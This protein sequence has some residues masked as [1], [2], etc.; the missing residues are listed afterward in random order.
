MTSSTTPSLLRC[1]ISSVKSRIRSQIVV[2]V[3]GVDFVVHSRAFHGA[4]S[5]IWEIVWFAS[6]SDRVIIFC[7]MRDSDCAA[8][9]VQRSGERAGNPAG[10]RWDDR[11]FTRDVITNAPGSRA[12]AARSGRWDP[13]PRQWA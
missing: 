6:R 2:P 1:L 3:P 7:L 13:P 8:L 9:Q 10:E 5:P 4:R 11:A 12:A